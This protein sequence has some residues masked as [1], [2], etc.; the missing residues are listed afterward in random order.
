MKL[1]NHIAY[2]F[3]TDES[4]IIEMI[5]ATY[6]YVKF[7]DYHKN[8]KIISLF[9]TLNPKGN[10]TYYCTDSV[11]DKLDMLQVKRKNSEYNWSVF[12][13][14][15]NG[16]F[17]F[18]FSDNKLIRLFID[19]NVIHI[20]FVKMDMEDEEKGNMKWTMFYLDKNT[21]DKCEHFIHKDVQEIEEFCYKLLCFVYLTENE[22]I[23]IN[24]KEKYG[25]KK[26]GKIINTLPFPLTIIN[27]KW[28]ITT[29]R[30]DK[31]EVRGHFAIRWTG[32]GRTIP[33]LV[34]IEPFEK[35]GYVRKAKSLNQ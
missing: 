18:I 22:E 12:N 8:T 35:N 20:T 6:P 24:T 32:E 29:I 26:T 14:I 31:I 28:N 21:G 13:S 16:K 15:N 10:K 17:T 5:K 34:F 11:I 30:T 25:T 4:I 33:K 3:L 27:S 2:R 7:E 9:N 19:D 23:I 1:Q